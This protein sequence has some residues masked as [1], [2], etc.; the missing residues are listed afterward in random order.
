M[1][2]YTRNTHKIGINDLIQDESTS[3]TCYEKY[4]KK[5]FRRV[6]KNLHPLVCTYNDETVAIIFEEDKPRI[7]LTSSEK[8]SINIRSYV[9]EEYLKIISSTLH[10]KFNQVDKITRRID[11]IKEEYEN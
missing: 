3:F 7:F 11:Q 1:K 2:N 6:S 9:N 4:Y 8:I 5:L 10:C